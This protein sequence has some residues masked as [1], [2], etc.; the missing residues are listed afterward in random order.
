MTAREEAD[1]LTLRACDKDL[2][3]RGPSEG[4]IRH[5]YT[6]NDTPYEYSAA[7]VGGD[8]P[9]AVLTMWVGWFSRSAD[10]ERRN[11]H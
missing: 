4:F 3:N 9:G 11:V 6:S 8:R 10:L 2:I 1:W 7:S 5:M